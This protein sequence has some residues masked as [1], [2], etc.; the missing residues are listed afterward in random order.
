MTDEKNI[1]CIPSK[2]NRMV[3]V[4]YCTVLYQK[5]LT[6]WYQTLLA[7]SNWIEIIHHAVSQ[8][9]D[10]PELLYAT[11]VLPRFVLGQM[12]GAP[13]SILRTSFI[14]SFIVPQII[15][16]RRRP[17]KMNI[18]ISTVLVYWNYYYYYYYHHDHNALDLRY[19]STVQYSTT[20]EE[21]M[22]W[23]FWRSVE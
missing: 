12:H 2:S 23:N 15:F 4:L 9:L 18:L 17:Y 11:T 20:V 3:T 7:N 1:M 14:H 13:V 16:I 19:Y 8:S 10:F 22:N 5:S 6:A 21:R